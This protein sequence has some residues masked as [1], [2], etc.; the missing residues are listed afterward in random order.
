MKEEDLTKAIQIKKQLDYERELLLFANNRNV[1]LKVT[2]EDNC[3]HG[4]IRDVGY[5]F[6]DSLIEEMKAEVIAKI[7]KSANDLLDKLEKL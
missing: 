4:R 7:E 2:L 5:I 3:D 6:G 1:K